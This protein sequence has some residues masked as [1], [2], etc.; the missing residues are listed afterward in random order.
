MY[1]NLVVFWVVTLIAMI[2]F[3][4]FVRTVTY[5]FINKKEERTAK[6]K[7]IEEDAYA[8][9]SG[10]RFINTRIHDLDVKTNRMNERIREIE[11]GLKSKGKVS[12]K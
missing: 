6:I 7:Q 12:K 4:I 1:V 3:A 5:H 8:A 2:G 11:K 10:I 9:Q